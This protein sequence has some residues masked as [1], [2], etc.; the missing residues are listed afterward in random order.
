MK[1]DSLNV[2]EKLYELSLKFVAALAQLVGA[3]IAK[4]EARR[5]TCRIDA[6]DATYDLA[7]YVRYGQTT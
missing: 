5:V 2:D 6:V 4:D 1:L 7:Y 3:M